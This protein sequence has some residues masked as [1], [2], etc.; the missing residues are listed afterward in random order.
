MNRWCA[1]VRHNHNHL[2]GLGTSIHFKSN[3][4]KGKESIC[5]TGQSAEQTPATTTRLRLLVHELIQMAEVTA[6]GRTMKTRRQHQKTNIIAVSESMM[7][8]EKRTI[9]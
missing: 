3:G 2:Q 7:T 1:M 6:A 8:R 5:Q 4:D 9:G